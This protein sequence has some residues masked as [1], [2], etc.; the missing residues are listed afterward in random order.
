MKGHLKKV[1]RL[2]KNEKT[3]RFLIRFLKPTSRHL[4]TLRDFQIDLSAG[5]IH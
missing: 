1:F 2:Y 3:H 4:Y 5:L